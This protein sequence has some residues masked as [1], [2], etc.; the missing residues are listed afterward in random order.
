MMPLR[1]RK[2]WV[3]EK[4]GTM[5][6]TLDSNELKPDTH[7]AIVGFD[8]VAQLTDEVYFK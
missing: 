2:F 6:F 8:R 1:P 7:L 3:F 4:A 5:K